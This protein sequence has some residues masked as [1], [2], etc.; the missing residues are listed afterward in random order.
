MITFGR[1]G[2]VRFDSRRGANLSVA[3]ADA[4]VAASQ[5]PVLDSA[6]EKTYDKEHSVKSALKKIN[7]AIRQLKSTR[8]KLSGQLS[9]GGADAARSEAAQVQ[10]QRQQLHDKLRQVNQQLA[11]L[12]CPRT[13][14]SAASGDNLPVG[15]S[16]VAEP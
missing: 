15:S 16:G 13:A 12:G 9:Q 4:K 11:E 5:V 3:R 1:P 10:S 2:P 8:S 7:N 14:T 6:I